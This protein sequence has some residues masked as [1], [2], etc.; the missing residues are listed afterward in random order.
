MIKIIVGIIEGSN[1]FNQIRVS[2]R[3]AHGISLFLLTAMV[4][5]LND[6]LF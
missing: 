2:W 6:L 1:E 5:F 3:N 4:I